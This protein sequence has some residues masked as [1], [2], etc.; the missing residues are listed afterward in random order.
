MYPII[1]GPGDQNSDPLFVDPINNNYNLGFGSPC[2]GTG[3]YGGDRG[4]LPTP[5]S[6]ENA[7]VP[8]LFTLYNNYPNPFNARTIISFSLQHDSEVVIDVFDLLGRQV[9]LIED[10]Y[11]SAGAHHVIWDAKGETSGL[12][13]YRL[14]A[15]GHTETR[16]CLLLK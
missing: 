7:T 13:F 2:I 9:A 14:S 8:N 15:D 5:S 10:R 11:F 1:P 4:A 16:S 12:Y 6:V 3:R